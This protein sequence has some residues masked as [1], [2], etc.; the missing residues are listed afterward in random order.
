MLETRS[1]ITFTVEILSRFTVYLWIK[2]VKALNQVFHYLN[3][4]IHIEII[5]S[6]SSFKLFLSFNYSNSDYDETVVKKDHKS[7]FRYIFFVIRGPVSWSC[8]C[9]SIVATSSTEAEYI[10]Q[11]NASR[12]A[13]WIQ[14]FLQEL[15][16]RFE[17]LIDQLTVV[18]ADNNGARSLSKNPSI[19]SWVKHM[20]IKFYWQHQQVEHGFLQF[21]YIPSK[22]NGADGFT[23]LKDPTLFKYFRDRLIHL[24]TNISVQ[25]SR[26]NS[27][28]GEVLKAIQHA[29]SLIIPICW[30]FRLIFHISGFDD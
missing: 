7:I 29:D 16:Y 30:L 19:H 11:Y 17:N 5:Y 4:T 13:I 6:H 22:E 21:N 8:K 24:T 10:A 15:E 9:Q 18:Y 3:K 20:E 28:W 12:E 14:T 25:N 2:H 27:N 1:D 23:K 26:N